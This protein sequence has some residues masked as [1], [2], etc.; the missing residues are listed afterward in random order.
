MPA[1][2]V[3]VNADS[4]EQTLAEVAAALRGARGLPTLCVI[5][6]RLGPDTM[7]SAARALTAFD[8]E[9]P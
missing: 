3:V 6:Y 7:A 4:I 5:G 8:A 9:A 1:P 2:T